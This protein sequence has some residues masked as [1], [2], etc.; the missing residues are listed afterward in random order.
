M[1]KTERDFA[2]PTTEAVFNRT[3]LEMS[4]VFTKAGM[5]TEKVLFQWGLLLLVVGFLLGRALILMKIMPFALPFF[6]AVMAIKKEKAP[7]AS[8]A[9]LAGAFSVSIQNGGTVFATLFV[10]LLI[11]RFSGM[12]TIDPL[13]KL[14]FTVFIAMLL[15]KLTIFYVF[16]KEFTMYDFTFVAVEAGLSFILTMIFLQSVPLI[17]YRKRKQ[18]LKTE[19]VIS[20]II[21]LASVM[22]GTIGWMIYGLSAEHILSRYLVLVFAFVSGPTIGATVG[23]V[24]GLILSFANVS[25]LYEM[26]LLAFSGLLGGLLKDGKKLGAALGLVVGS[27]LIGLYAQADQGLTT[28]L[29]E[30]LTAVVLFLL[31]PSFVL[32]NLSKL[33]PGTSENM[34]EQQQYVRK[35]RDV[36][37]NRVE[38]FSNV[39][40]AL[41][42]S[43][44]QNGF[45]DEKPSADKEVDY[46]LSSVTERTCQFC[47]KK[48]QC[49]AQQFDTTYEYMKEIMLEV[50]NGTLEQ[51]PR[52]IREM[53]KHCVKSKKVIDVIE[54]ELTYFK[55]NQHLKAQIQES[56]RIVAEQLHGVSE[57][58]GNFAKEIKREREN[59][60]VQEEQIL[61]ALR[62]FGMEINQI[63]IYSL[64]PG[65]VDIE[66]W[67]PYC[68][69]RGECEKIIAPMLTDILG[70]S[71]VVKNEECAK[72]P[73]GYCHVSFGCTKAYVVDTGVA[74]AAK[75]GGFVSGDS[76]SMIELNAGKYALA[77]S[78]GMGNGERAHYES[79]ETLQLLKQILQTGI[80]ETI[81]IKS[82]N[83]ILSLRTN[84]EIFSTLDLAMIDLQDANVNFLKIG[85][86]PSF[87]KR[88]DKVIKIQ[89]SNLPMGIIE[90]FEVDVVN[91]QMKAEDLLIM[92]SDGVFE[93][94]KHVENYEMWMKRKIG[95]L[96]TNDPQE[97]ADLI[98]EEVIRTK[99]GLI[100]DD[101]TVVV[102]KLQHNTP[103]WSSIPSYA[104]RKKAQ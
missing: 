51:N 38:Q 21:L 13:K 28:N 6:A 19:E 27:L 55:A 45:Y 12:L 90:E 85:S 95:E 71:I 56:R 88:G 42:K 81:A 74:H 1:Q 40:Q 65:N 50:D 72:Y 58:M 18:S 98:M 78:D 25:S 49:W 4:R 17:S 33:V 24:T 70:E 41:S 53:D 20:L 2:S 87:I 43:F 92:M 37:A 54:H 52:L 7:L 76:Y 26:S 61:E 5:K 31:T 16:T 44:T 14:P 64:E 91:E 34:L 22:T 46:F 96:Q 99:S 29:Y 57:V 36:T 47:F 63:E 11:H 30:S 102:A 94:P 93:G 3:R 103:K 48:E 8:L 59:L 73:Q 32:K 80:E 69:G 82:I 77:I 66:M 86:T 15:T 83:S 67:V 39:F 35:I 89:A 84:D 97:I 100:E 68:H 23:V 104:Y 9:V 60:N 62:N 75:G 79:S 101:M 10:F